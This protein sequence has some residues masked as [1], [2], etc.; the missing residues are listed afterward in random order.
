M[1]AD[2]EGGGEE[3]DITTCDFILNSNCAKIVC[4]AAGLCPDPQ[5]AIKRF[6]T[7][8]KPQ[9]AIREGTIPHI[10][11]HSYVRFA[12]VEG[13]GRRVDRNRKGELEGG[14]WKI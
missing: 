5:G 6:L 7:L 1:K 13:R 4:L 8:A 14:L 9:W 10:S 2:M 11:S 3:Y 12:V